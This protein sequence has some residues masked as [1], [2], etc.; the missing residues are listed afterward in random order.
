MNAGLNVGDIIFQLFT[1]GSIIIFIGIFFL[2]L[3][4]SKKKK[5]QLDRIENKLNSLKDNKE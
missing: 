2:F 4:S 1:F 3:R 5:E